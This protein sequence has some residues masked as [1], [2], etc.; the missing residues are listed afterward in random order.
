MKPDYWER[1]ARTARGAGPEPLADMPFGFDARA[2]AR[3]PGP[4]LRNEWGT[5]RV[6]LR[7]ALACAT[8]VMLLSVA[9][10][11][12]SLTES[13]ASEMAI[14]DATARLSLWP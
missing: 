13:D 11:Y 1:L 9:L 14:A 7:A 8:L 6:M 3:R 10:N 5:W 4:A 12:R 2:V